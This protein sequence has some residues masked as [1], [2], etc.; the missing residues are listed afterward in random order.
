MMITDRQR[1]IIHLLQ[2]S[3]LTS[4][5]IAEYL[6]V[7]TRTVMR[8][9]A[10]L[11][12]SFQTNNLAIIE[13]NYQGQGYHLVIYDN[14]KFHKHIELKPDVPLNIL[15]ALTHQ[16]EVLL[17]DLQEKFYLSKTV[18]VKIL[19]QLKAN[20]ATF[21]DINAKPSKGYQLISSYSTRLFLTANILLEDK[22]TL[23]SSFA[24]NSATYQQLIA[25][26][27]LPKL[28]HHLSFLTPSQFVLLALAATHVFPDSMNENGM[29]SIT[30]PTENTT[31]LRHFLLH[32]FAQL[33]AITKIKVEPKQLDAFIHHL[34]TI[35]HQLHTLSIENINSAFNQTSMIFHM[36]FKSPS[37]LIVKIFNHLERCI[38]FP[39]LLNNFDDINQLILV[40]PMI[41]NFSHYFLNALNKIQDFTILDDS[42]TFL[43][44]LCAHSAYQT[45]YPIHLISSRWSIANINKKLIEDK[46]PNAN[47]ICYVGDTGWENNLA[48][49]YVIW[50]KEDAIP[51][52]LHIDMTINAI[53]EPQ[54]L[55]LLKTH[56]EELSVKF[57]IKQRF[58]QNEILTVANKNNTWLE[59]I[60]QCCHMLQERNWIE[61]QDARQIVLREN[62]GH[63]LIIN[64]T[65]IP[66]ATSVYVEQFALFYFQLDNTQTIDG[67]V[68]N[69]VLL[70]LVNPDHKE[71]SNIFSYLYKMLN[72]Y[73]KEQL[74]QITSLKELQAILLENPTRN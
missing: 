17:I 21:V 68:V 58:R 50:N 2:K 63:S 30:D 3:D 72:H 27:D 74:A 40:N 70:V 4:E 38:A 11:N 71:N 5:K 65:A 69:H 49:Q 37:S 39:S 20:Y 36:Q 14:H 62:Q 52:S 7:S 10:E 33:S 64:N 41:Y 53:I 25:L 19:T 1:K 42:Y 23:F 24:L 54:A 56:L 22:A 28:T 31:E 13:A 57:G 66:H 32:Y 45:Q 59:T 18:V 35:Q 44:F 9:I 46:I 48:Q 8:D 67:Q 15:L 34:Q 47:V 26:V 60:H 16:P 29:K 6:D 43:Y 12:D 61:L 51:E 73:T 55:T